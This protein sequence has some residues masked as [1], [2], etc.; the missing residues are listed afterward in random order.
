M[1]AH[2][3]PITPE[4]NMVYYCQCPVKCV[5]CAHSRTLEEKSLAVPL[6]LSAVRLISST[7]CKRSRGPQRSDALSPSCV[8]TTWYCLWL[9]ET[10]GKLFSLCASEFRCGLTAVSAEAQFPSQI[11]KSAASVYGWGLLCCTLPSHSLEER[12]QRTAGPRQ[13]HFGPQC[14]SSLSF[15]QYAAPH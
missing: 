2:M 14:N 7:G 10:T 13:G 6:G 5:I 11:L 3:S 15:E 4:E 1:L 8:T 9:C 12:M